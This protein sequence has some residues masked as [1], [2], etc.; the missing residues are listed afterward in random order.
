VPRVPALRHFWIQVQVTEL[1]ELVEGVTRNLPRRPA[2][3]A[4]EGQSPM[5][6]EWI[7]GEILAVWVQGSGTRQDYRLCRVDRPT[8]TASTSEFPITWLDR[9]LGAAHEGVLPVNTQPAPDSHESNRM[10]EECIKPHSY[11]L[12]GKEPG[13]GISPT[14]VLCRVRRAMLVTN[15]HHNEV[16]AADIASAAMNKFHCLYF[17][18]Y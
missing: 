17:S 6:S 2:E 11:I 4:P 12:G 9:T 14:S 15:Q 18:P 5:A 16:G 10:Y 13:G 8:P 7:K 1:E 3:V